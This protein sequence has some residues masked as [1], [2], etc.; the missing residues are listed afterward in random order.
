G[1]AAGA[2]MGV[3]GTVDM[4]NRLL[5]LSDTSKIY[6]YLVYNE[7]CDFICPERF[8]EGHGH[9]PKIGVHVGVIKI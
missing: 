9:T 3:W 1:Y 4:Y 8:I 5:D 7:K 2:G 6:N